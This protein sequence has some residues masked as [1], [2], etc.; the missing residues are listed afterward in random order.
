MYSERNKKIELILQLVIRDISSRFKGSVLGKLW[1]V[2]TPILMLVIYT[3]V[4]SFVFKMRWGTENESLGFFALNIMIGM[5][6]FNFFSESI[7]RST[8][9]IR[10]NSSYVKRVVFQLNIL[11]LVTVLSSLFNFLIA[12][13]VFTIGYIIVLGIPDMGF[14]EFFIL[15]IPLV[16]TVA[17][18]SWFI[19]TLGVFF[20]DLQHLIGTM[21]MMLMFMTPVFYSLDLV[22]SNIKVYLYLNPLVYY[23]EQSRSVL[24]NQSGLDFNSL[25]VSYIISMAIFYF[26]YKW[27]NKIS[28]YFADVI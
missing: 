24:F 10:D 8:T 2:T 6:L 7:N 18:L 13:G 12:F 19:A 25:G 27:F 5:V 22:P 9:I 20:R 17:G 15:L 11:P 16:L 23:I 14:L 3:F 26:G 28:K 4:F 1:L 21:L